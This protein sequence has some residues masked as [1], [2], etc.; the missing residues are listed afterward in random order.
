MSFPKALAGN[1]WSN[2]VGII[3]LNVIIHSIIDK[4][5][6]DRTYFEAMSVIY[7]T[8]LMMISNNYSFC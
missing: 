6:L 5:M 7:L 4:I 1:S 8:F 2:A 3:H